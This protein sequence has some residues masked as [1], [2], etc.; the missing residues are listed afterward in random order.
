MPLLSKNAFTSN[1]NCTNR[2]IYAIYIYISVYI[3]N[4]KITNM[5]YFFY[6]LQ[7]SFSEFLCTLLMYS[8]K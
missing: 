1:T 2:E 8:K 5:I 3:A 4:I 7:S 6:I